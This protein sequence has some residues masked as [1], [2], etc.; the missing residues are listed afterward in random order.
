[1]ASYPSSV[2]RPFL[3]SRDHE[4]G[5]G[6]I[7]SEWCHIHR[8]CV[9]SVVHV[10]RSQARTRQITSVNGAYPSP[11]R[12]FIHVSRSRARTRTD[13]KC[14]WCHI[15][16]PCVRS[17]VHVS[18]SRARMQQITIVNGVISIARVCGPLF[19]SRD[20]EHARGQITSV[21]G[22]ISIVRVCGPLF[23]SRDHEHGRSRL[24]L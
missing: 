23:M 17:V 20:H 15:H 22:V 5:R 12:S 18:R 14:E 19:M 9:R 16:R 8:P 4:H 7:T 3:M 2:C 21:N 10:S 11:V 1:M 24:Q 13:Y 6:Q